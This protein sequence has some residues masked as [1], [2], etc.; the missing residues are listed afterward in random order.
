MGLELGPP[1]GP[2]GST[3]PVTSAAATSG[4]GSPVRI[5][6]RRT[7]TYTLPGITHIL[8]RGW[9]N[10]PTV[11]PYAGRA[12]EHLPSTGI[13]DSANLAGGPAGSDHGAQR[14]TPRCEAQ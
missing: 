13:G 9:P 6:S 4:Q 10:Y 2:S 11:E 5:G 14:G 8:G 7:A 3:A 1:A 12:K